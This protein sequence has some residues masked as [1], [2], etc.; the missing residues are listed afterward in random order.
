[1]PDPNQTETHACPCR[2]DL[3]DFHDGKLPPVRLE[4]VAAHVE[5]CD[6][7]AER[8][9]TFVGDADA[10]V[11]DLRRH[12]EAEPIAPEEASRASA[13]AG[14]VAAPGGRESADV[15]QRPGA[16][17]G[18]YELVELLGEG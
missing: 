3:S 7:C 5:T 11:R 10:L 13:I 15:T 18:P 9:S 2:A 4:A 8:L 16:V 6:A 17:L 14:G 12:P 1:M